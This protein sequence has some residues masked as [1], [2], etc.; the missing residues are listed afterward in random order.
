MKK[1]WAIWKLISQ[2][3]RDNVFIKDREVLLIQERE[4]PVFRFYSDIMSNILKNELVCA[5]I[6]H[7]VKR[8]VHEYTN[9]PKSTPSSS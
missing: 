2:S 7:T 6:L 8:T 4:P 5:I 3:K 1:S 9:T